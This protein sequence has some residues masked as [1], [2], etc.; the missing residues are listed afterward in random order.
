[1]SGYSTSF[2]I[3]DPKQDVIKFNLQQ[4]QTPSD[5]E[6]NLYVAW[7]NASSGSPVANLVVS[8]RMDGTALKSTGNSVFLSGHGSYCYDNSVLQD[9]V[10]EVITINTVND[11][12]VVID[13]KT[14]S[15]HADCDFEGWMDLMTNVTRTSLSFLDISGNLS[16]SLTIRYRITNFCDCKY[17]LNSNSNHGTMEPS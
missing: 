5:L 10:A 15:N 16:Q 4:N 6:L 8:Y 7:Y 12:V 2:Q 11:S 14:S 13:G 1:M 9:S 3:F 17:S